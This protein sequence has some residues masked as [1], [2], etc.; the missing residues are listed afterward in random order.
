MC[1]LHKHTNGYRIYI[2]SSSKDELINLVKPYF[3]DHFYY[4]L[5]LD[6]DI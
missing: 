5:D 4:K 1:S 6:S 2:F 3:L